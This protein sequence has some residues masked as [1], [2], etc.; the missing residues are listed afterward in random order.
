MFLANIVHTIQ[1]YSGVD[2]HAINIKRHCKIYS[3]FLLNV[4]LSVM[5]K[6]NRVWSPLNIDWVNIFL[7]LYPKKCMLY[8]LI[9]FGIPTKKMSEYWLYM[10][11]FYILVQ[12]VSFYMNVIPSQII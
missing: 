5:H 8:L 4:K 3:T 7:I 12:V 6:H 9:V 2:A 10:F 1:C 11:I